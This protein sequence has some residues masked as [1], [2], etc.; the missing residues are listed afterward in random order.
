MA[1]YLLPINFRISNEKE[2]PNLSIMDTMILTKPPRGAQNNSSE[3]CAY[4]PPTTT[5]VYVETEG[6][7]CGSII[8]PEIPE[9]HTGLEIQ[10]HD[11]ANPDKEWE[12]NFTD[13][14]WQTN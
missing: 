5:M 6:A 10:A 8:D 12:N 11:F 1:I 4:V 2:S 13:N 9:S 14:E 7:F 3:R